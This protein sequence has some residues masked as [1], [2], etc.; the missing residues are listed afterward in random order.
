[1]PNASLIS[2]NRLE[3]SFPGGHLGLRDVDLNVDAG[4]FVSIVGPSGCGKSTLLRLVAGLLE[5]T[6]GSISVNESSPT[7]ANA[8]TAFVFQE[9][10]LLP[11][12]TLEGNIR[13]PL[14]LDR[15]ADPPKSAE[16][17]RRISESIELIGLDKGDARKRPR[18]LSGGMRMRVSLGRAL[19]TEPEILLLDEPFAALDDI[20]RQQ[21]NEEL[22]RIWWTKRW[23][24][25]F[26]THNVSEAVFLSQRVL[27]MS[28]CPGRLIADIN[29]PFDYPRKPELRS[30]AE[31]AG[32]VG[33]VSRRL[34][35]AA[36]EAV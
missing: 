2:A 17:A 11:W 15:E 19:V 27:V 12:R 31:F 5:P 26:V 33:E 1:M 25:L 18:Q 10:N 14:E 36:E 21:L 30:T 29:V 22:Q 7:E 13:L 20:L 28:R 4:S 34:R 8:K 16:M 3:M 32:L 9:P 23:T 35:Q 24:G 6:A